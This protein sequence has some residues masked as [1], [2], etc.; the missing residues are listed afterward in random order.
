[1]DAYLGGE[2][3]QDAVDGASQQ[4]PP[5]Q[6]AGQHHVGEEGAEIHHLQRRQGPTMGQG[7]PPSAASSL[8]VH[9]WGT[10]ASSDICRKQSP[11]TPGHGANPTACLAYS[12]GRNRSTEK[13]ESAGL[14]LGLPFSFQGLAGLGPRSPGPRGS[15]RGRGALRSP[16]LTFFTS[17]ACFPVP[18]CPPWDLP[19]PQSSYDRRQPGGHSQG[20]KAK[21]SEDGPASHACKLCD[22]F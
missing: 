13:L 4:Q 22:I 11:G 7:P 9:S 12:Q 16:D 6:E 21:T 2:H 14:G 19:R 8:P 5:N 18:G 15:P 3:V 10:R 1:M 20:S 17:Q